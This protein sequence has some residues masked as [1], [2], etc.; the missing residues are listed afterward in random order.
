MYQ[1]NRHWAHYTIQELRT[2]KE[3]VPVLFLFDA[4]FAIFFCD[5]IIN[6]FC[7]L[8]DSMT[9]TCLSMISYLQDNAMITGFVRNGCMTIIKMFVC[10]TYGYASKLI[11]GLTSYSI[12]SPFDFFEISRF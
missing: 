7:V 9:C 4:P 5:M 11:S 8:M 1:V 6:L 3:T 12:I 2:F 10:V